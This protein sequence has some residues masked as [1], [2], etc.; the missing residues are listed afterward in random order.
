MPRSRLDLQNVDAIPGV[1]GALRPDAIINCAAFTDVDGA[2]DREELAGLVNGHAVGALAAWASDRGVPFLTFS[3]DYVFDG[4]AG[5]P[6]MESSLPRPINV[7]GR[8]KLTGER[9]AL[10]A[11]ALVVRTSWLISDSHPNFVATMIRLGRE[12][13]LKVVNDQYG[14]PTV[15]RDLAASAYRA[16]NND[17]TGLVHLTN[18]GAATWFELARTSLSQAG[19]NP[20]NIA[21]CTTE[22]F[23]SAA[24]RPAYSV[25]GTERAEQLKDMRMPHWRDSLPGLVEGVLEW[26]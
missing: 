2:E 23:A 4:T 17:L 22:E 26:V 20:G 10:Q 11:G 12:R 15:A 5:S 8:S 19:L 14:C 24:D 6:Y 16:L 18:Q 21:P 3:T 25:L 1:L 9:L 13:E 7:Y